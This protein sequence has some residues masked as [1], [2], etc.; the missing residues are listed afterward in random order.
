MGNDISDSN[1]MKYFKGPPTLTDLTIGRAVSP[2]V[3]AA[4]HGRMPNLKGDIY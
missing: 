4:L 1:L 3:K 2:E